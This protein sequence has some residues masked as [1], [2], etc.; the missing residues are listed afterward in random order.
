M[1]TSYRHGWRLSTPIAHDFPKRGGYPPINIP[2]FTSSTWPVMY[3]AASDARNTTGCAISASVPGRPS[4]IWLDH[5]L[6]QFLAQHRRHRRLDISRRN[7]IHCNPTRSHLARQRPRE[8]DQT[9]LRRRV[10]HL[11]LLPRAAHH[12][13]DVDD[14]SPAILHHLPQQCLRQQKRPSQI[15]AQHVI[16]IG[17]FHTHHQIVARDARVI[18]QDLHLAEPIQ[19]RLRAVLDRLLAGHIECKCRRLSAR[20]RNLRR[21]LGQLGLIARR[22]RHRGSRL[23]HFQR[24]RPPDPLRRSSHQRNSSLQIRHPAPTFSAA[25]TSIASRTSKANYRQAH[26]VLIPSICRLTETPIGLLLS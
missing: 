8:S 22:Q 24:T 21:H 9:R 23:R 1:Q 10:I 7:G 13:R 5:L 2:P 16:P 14:P 17:A 6:A 26:V 20:C 11:A 3:A 19:H 4:G 25:L 18:D 12:A 15:R